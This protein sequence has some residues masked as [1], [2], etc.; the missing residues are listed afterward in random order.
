QWLV[1]FA[2]GQPLML[3]SPDW[4]RDRIAPESD[5]VHWW[6]KF[7][8]GNGIFTLLTAGIGTGGSA[9]PILLRA[10]EA[11]PVLLSPAASS[12]DAAIATLDSAER[13]LPAAVDEV[14]S[15]G[16]LVSDGAEAAA[17]ANRPQQIHHFATNKSKTY[18]PKMKEIADKF[19]L[20][21][22][23]AWNK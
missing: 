9:A 23:T 16:K 2:T 22:D 3:E 15:Q 7:L 17:A 21:L 14:L 19:G 1:S 11:E 10:A 4:S 18:T 12:V 8:G 20:D 13:A 5:R 6:S